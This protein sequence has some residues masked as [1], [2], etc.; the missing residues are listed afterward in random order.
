[1]KTKLTKV[2]PVGNKLLLSIPETKTGSL[3]VQ[4]GA[5]IQEIGTVIDLGEYV[6]MDA[7]PRFKKGDTLHFK[8]WAVDII[9]VDGEKFYYISADSDAICGLVS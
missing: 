6:L 2:K 5:Q 4:Q 8:A 9:T 1:M 7:K 3:V